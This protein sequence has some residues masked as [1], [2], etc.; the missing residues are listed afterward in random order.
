MIMIIIIL[1][2]IIVSYVI[3][4]AKTFDAD[5]T[6]QMDPAQVSSNKVRHIFID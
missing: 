6:R 5:D 1:I 3:I 4:K 2:V